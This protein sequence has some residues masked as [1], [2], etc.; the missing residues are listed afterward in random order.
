[1]ISALDEDKG[2]GRKDAKGGGGKSK[3]KAGKA[4]SSDEETR[5]VEPVPTEAA[6][7][8]ASHGL[9]INKLDSQVGDM[10]KTVTAPRDPTGH[11]K[12]RFAKHLQAL[13]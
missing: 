6:S 10:K 7:I 12:S 1:M 2:K 9:Q 5:P 4:K 11:Y 3:G 8:A 13:Y